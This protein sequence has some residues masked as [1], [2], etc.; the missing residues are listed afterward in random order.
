MAIDKKNMEEKAAEEEMKSKVQPEKRVKIAET[1][2]DQKVGE[3]K[4][5][6]IPVHQEQK[7]KDQ[8]KKKGV[9][10]KTAQ[11]LEKTQPVLEPS[12][13]KT[14]N[15]KLRKINHIDPSLIERALCFAHP[16]LLEHR[17]L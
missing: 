7:V 9:R 12:L 11:S 2:T 17:R 15:S 1:T 3:V 13:P 14:S 16:E 4:E 6:R 5:E 10:A 8:S